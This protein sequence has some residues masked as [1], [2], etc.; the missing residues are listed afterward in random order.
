MSRT[1]RVTSACQS[2][3]ALARWRRSRRSKARRRVHRLRLRRCRR[4][5]S[6]ARRRSASSRWREDSRIRGASRFLAG[7]LHARHRARGPAAHHPQRRARSGTDRRR[8]QGLCARAGRTARC[9]AA[10]RIRAEPHRL[11]EL[12]EGRREQPLD[13]GARARP[14]GWRGAHRR[15]GHLRRQ[16]LEQV[17]HELRRPHRV[18]S[19]WLPVSDARRAPGA[20]TRAGHQ[21]SRRQGD[22][23]PRRRQR[24]AGQPVR[25][26]VG[27]SAGDLHARSSQPA[28]AGD[29]SG[30]RRAVGERAR[31]ARRRRA[32]HPAG[33]E[34]TTA[35]RSSPS[36]PTT[37][38]RRSATRRRAPISSRR[39]CT[40]CR[41]SRSRG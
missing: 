22:P 4:P 1:R 2:G 33:R 35:G 29:E 17:E 8:S 39:S 5:S 30:D 21:G 6:A 36:A 7:W 24:A 38:A 28:G 3:L 19:R 34:R 37:T 18:R 11:S 16:H 15:Q 12:L 26:Q 25:G 31:P 9:R 10:S 13:D 32:E 27:I 40:G 14:A 20:A 23:A 41:R